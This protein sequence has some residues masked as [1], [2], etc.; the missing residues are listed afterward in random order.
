MQNEILLSKMQT[1]T[2]IACGFSKILIDVLAE[3]WN[4]L[5]KELNSAGPPIKRVSE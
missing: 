4:S 5:S 3:F 1:N 2:A